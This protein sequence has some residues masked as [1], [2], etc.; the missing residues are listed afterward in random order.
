LHGH[1][2]EL[3]DIETNLLSLPGVRDGVIVPKLKDDR[4]EWLAAFVILS[5]RPTDSEFEVSRILR[6]RLAERLPA[7]M[8][9]RKFYFLPAFPLTPN[10][11]ID[12]LKLAEMIE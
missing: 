9:P 6:S 7:Y 5:E 1:R 3:G 4:A 11:K 10:G 2:I 8:L 12:R